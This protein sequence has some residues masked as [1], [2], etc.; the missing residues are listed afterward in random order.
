MN[1]GRSTDGR[2]WARLSRTKIGDTLVADAG[3][4]CLPP[5][6]HQ[7]VANDTGR[8]AVRCSHGLHFLDGQADD[9]DHL[10]G[11]WPRAVAA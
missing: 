1:A 10:I 11:L 8:L 6:E 4:E 2:E 7:V 9:G 5:G 3:F